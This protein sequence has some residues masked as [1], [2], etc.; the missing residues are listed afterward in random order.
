MITD[1]PVEVLDHRAAEYELQKHLRVLHDQHGRRAAELAHIVDGRRDAATY[2]EA[3]FRHV[4]RCGDQIQIPGDHK[5]R[6][7]DDADEGPDP[8]EARHLRAAVPTDAARH[9]AP[10][11]GRE[12]GAP[13]GLAQRTGN[14]RRAL[15]GGEHRGRLTDDLVAHAIWPVT[16]PERRR[17]E[18]QHGGAQQAPTRRCLFD[19]QSMARKGDASAVAFCD[20]P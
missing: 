15:L 9:R 8:D 10:P 19:V 11:S 6:Y 20:H 18:Y 2:G 7:D 3:G 14:K 5:T 4:L 17:K 1:G 12:A 16:R 13:C